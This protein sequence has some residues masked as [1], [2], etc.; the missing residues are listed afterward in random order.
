ML[1]NLLK[2][3]KNVISKCVKP[4][5]ESAKKAFQPQ[6]KNLQN[7][8]LG[9]AAA[10][11]LPVVNSPAVKSGFSQVQKALALP[12]TVAPAKKEVAST[13]Q[14][15]SNNQAKQL[16]TSS[17]S[18]APQ[19]E[20]VKLLEEYKGNE[21]SKLEDIIRGAV[22]SD[23]FRIAFNANSSMGAMPGFLKV[24]RVMTPPEYK[25]LNLKIPYELLKAD[26]KAKFNQAGND[27]YNAQVPIASNLI[28]A[29]TNS[30][31]YKEHGPLPLETPEMNNMLAM[32]NYFMYGGRGGGILNQADVM[33]TYQ[34]IT[35]NTNMASVIGANAG[36]A[37]I[38]GGAGMANSIIEIIIDPYEAEK[39][40]F[41]LVTKSPV[42][43]PALLDKA[44]NYTKHYV[45]E[46]T[47]QE[48]AR[49]KGRIIFELASLAAFSAIGKAIK[50]AEAAQGA[51]KTEAL[52]KT[53]SEVSALIDEGGVSITKTEDVLT[54]NRGVGEV[55]EEG[56]KKGSGKLYDDIGNY[57][58]GRNKAE[59]DSLAH[60]PA[61]AGST[62]QYDIDQGLLEQKVGLSLEERGKVAGPLTRDPSGA[63]EF[64]DKNGQAWDVKSFN[65][66]YKPSKGG[67]TLQKSM[68]SILDSISKN[69]NVMLDTS[70]LSL[71]H[72][73]E[74]LNEI[75][76]QGLLDKV[77]LWP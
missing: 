63:A 42:I 20:N 58:G 7:S 50:G 11:L 22:K 24:L 23:A 54:A 41:N 55:L 8:T 14:S 39:N 40:L 3:T 62:R 67:Y 48:K 46:A 44:A 66:N 19:E 49:V 4:V 1:N 77:I 17:N 6:I 21:A 71:A 51:Q 29:F 73:T 31:D 57:T 47:P 68:D 35:N 28:G 30:S 74:L 61:H 12:K 70:N 32:M 75:T 27:A 59:L 45:T 72:K 5:L 56:V 53:G 18:P 36:G 69:E 15:S 38:D 64:F 26:I 10:K 65:S 2:V 43:I 34:N 33:S 76:K 37:L 52:A 60:D 13:P 16:S 9:K 25:S